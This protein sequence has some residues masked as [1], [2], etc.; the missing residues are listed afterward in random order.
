[1]SSTQ[2]IIPVIIQ[3]EM[4]D[5]YLDY[6][7]SVIIGRALPDVRDGLK[8][9]HRR[10]LYAMKAMSNYHNKPYVKSARVVGEVIGKYHPHGDTAV[11]HTIAR[12]AQEFSLRYPLID[13]QGNFGSIDGDSPAAMRYTEVR[14]EKLTG[15]MLKD[16]D[17]ETVN[18]KP[19]YDDKELEPTVL[20][21]KIPNLLINGSSGIAVGMAT[22]IPPH[23]LTEVMR[24]L[25]ALLKDPNL[26]IDQLME[27]IP[28]PDF[29]TAGEICG[30][31]GV[32][33]A[34]HNGKG[35]IQLRGKAEI[36]SIGKDKQ[37][38]V[39]T[40]LP[41]QV[42]KAKLLGKIKELVNEKVI[43]GISSAEDLSNS[44]GKAS[45]KIHI[46]LKKGEIAEVILNQLFK[47]TQLQVSFGI[48]LLAINNGSPKVL[49]LKQILR[50]FL[51]HRR[52]IIIRRTIY[53]LKKAKERAHLLEGLKIAV[54]NIDAMVAL[55][56][57]SDSPAIARTQMMAQFNLSQIQAQAVLDMKLQRLTGLE[58]EKIL[59]DYQEVLDM[60][61]ELDALLKS[62]DKISETIETEFAE[63]INSY[64]DPRRSRLVGSAK[65]ISI[66]DLTEKEDCIVT[67]THRGYLKRMPV[68]TYKTQKRG[69]SGVKGSVSKAGS[70]SI[71]QDED[72]FT[73]IFTAN[74]HDTL[75][76]FTNSGKM[77][78]RKVHQI[79]EGT[80]TSK[81]KNIANIL[82]I[83][84]SDKVMTIIVRPPE[85]AG[86]YLVFA[87]ER[88]LV[89]KSDL[90]YYEKIRQS[91]IQAIKLVSGDT[92]VNVGITSGGQ[93]I[94]LV[95]SSGKVIRFS[96]ADA[97]PK[98]R[99]SQGSRGIALVDDEKVIGME[100]VG[101]TGSILSV[102]EKGYGKRTDISGFRCQS[103]G[104]KGVMGMR[105]TLKTGNIVSIKC[106]EDTDDLMIITNKGQVIKTK[107]T[108]INVLGRQT[109]GVRIIKPKLDEKVVA[110]E[111]IVE[112]A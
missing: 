95:A 33:S 37:R 67:I 63:I 112:S 11:Y 40:E 26:T 78:S 9:V 5:C 18:W 14:M 7:M 30:K 16:L 2:D 43:T 50:C 91:G 42:N 92:I 47:H 4:R 25:I 48:N 71:N 39:I 101:K 81:G 109:Q 60:I 56:K 58:Q 28:G 17:K 53:Q 22:N 1:M 15:E 59:A 75:L 69:G 89:K 36:E 31:S 62:E 77:F 45:I 38:I 105:L 12:M 55:I 54:E 107:M 44:R 84:S 93:D 57:G 98:G 10:S 97:K 106:V 13:G 68:E 34:Y 21:A 90:A 74:T 6:A 72:F 35:I 88:G 104:G 27:I 87:T 23:N 3:D 70:G 86:K 20:P 64:D 52:E 102:T 46:D 110:I 80:R 83:S 111:N 85:V 96:E 73:D 32:K 99:V 49:N 94:M 82:P 100:I 61:S 103:R 65:E 51:D 66:E 41:Y 76:F 19:T 29:P 79:P 8:P 108:E 24:G